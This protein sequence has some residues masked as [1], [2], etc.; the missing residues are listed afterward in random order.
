MVREE[1]FERSTFGFRARCAANCATL[2]LTEATEAAS[3]FVGIEL[4]RTS[5]DDPERT[6]T[7]NDL[8]RACMRCQHVR[9]ATICLRRLVKIGSN[10]SNALI[11]EPGLPF[12]MTDPAGQPYL[13]ALFVLHET[14]AGLGT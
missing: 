5:H 14:A 9:Q 6:K 11:A 2:D 4:M 13:L 7:M 12:V 8:D 3:V 1:R 10:Q